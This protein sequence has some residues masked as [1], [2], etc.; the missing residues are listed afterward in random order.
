MVGLCTHVYAESVPFLLMWVRLVYAHGTYV[1]CRTADT[2]CSNSG[3]CSDFFSLRARVGKQ[4]L[5]WLFY[6]RGRG[7]FSFFP[8]FIL[9]CTRHCHHSSLRVQLPPIASVCLTSTTSAR[10]TKSP[11]PPPPQ[12]NHFRAI[13]IIAPLPQHYTT[14][15]ATAC[16]RP[17]SAMTAARAPA[18]ASLPA[19]LGSSTSTVTTSHNGKTT[20]AAAAASRS[21]N[22]QS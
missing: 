1:I 3:S 18:P 17:L 15:S 8:G 2:S 14:S 5:A 7:Y 12:S 13:A 21:S 16:N 10:A 22:Q 4:S 19:Q 6:A 9:H 11:L 20:A